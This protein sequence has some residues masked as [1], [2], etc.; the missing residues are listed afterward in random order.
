MEAKAELE[1]EERSEAP[2]WNL[3]EKPFWQGRISIHILL[4]SGDPEADLGY[5]GSEASPAFQ[6]AST[7]IP[8]VMLTFGE[9]F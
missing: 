7:L 5:G 9:A 6:K 2:H 3:K 8:E 1:G 4:V